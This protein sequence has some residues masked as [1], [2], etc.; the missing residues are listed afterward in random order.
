MSVQN[1]TPATEGRVGRPKTTDSVRTTSIAG[2]ALGLAAMVLCVTSGSARAVVVHAQT[3]TSDGGVKFDVASVKPNP[4][5]G[6]AP[7]RTQILPGGRYIA[8][9]IPLRLL[10]GQA[11]RVSSLRLVGGPDWLESTHYDINAKADRELFPTGGER[12]LDA[13]IKA[14]LAERFKLVVHNESK[15]MPIY[16]LVLDRSDRRFGPNLSAS[17]RTDCD[18]VLAARKAAAKPVGGGPPVPGGGGPPMPPGGGP[19]MSAGPGH[20]GGT[21]AMPCSARTFPGTLMADSLPLSF[22]AGVVAGEVNRMVEDR[23]GLTGRFN[24]RLTW[25]PEQMPQR[26]PGDTA[27][28]LPPIDPD[29]PSIFTAVKEQLGL[30]LDSTTGPIDV[31]V[32]DSVE[33]PTPD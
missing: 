14:L 16:A 18:A 5:G 33:R 15:Q 32:I 24:F 12:P 3:P 29:G 7:T 25:T 10:I 31:V 23:T 20:A 9:N 30:K 11:Y 1:E 27:A 8:T 19:P 26:P 17:P 22:L 13:A 21:D 2:L 6:D 28:N 4:A